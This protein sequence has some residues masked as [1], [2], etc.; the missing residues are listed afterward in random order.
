MVKNL[1]KIRN[2]VVADP[3]Q[4]ERLRKQNTRKR[5]R[6][7]VSLEFQIDWMIRKFRD[8]KCVPYIVL[9]D[10]LTLRL[11]GAEFYIKY[12]TWVQREIYFKRY[13]YKKVLW[14]MVDAGLIKKPV[15]H[16][17]I[18]GKQEIRYYFTKKGL[19]YKAKLA[20]PRHNRMPSTKNFL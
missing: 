19:E 20:K 11:F 15:R 17:F 18:S 14:K 8:S 3:V 13:V 5:I 9:N 4:R 16:K 7:D 6:R 2:H 1:E 12:K 10:K